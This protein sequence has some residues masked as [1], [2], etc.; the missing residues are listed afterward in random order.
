MGSRTGS[1]LGSSDLACNQ[2][3]FVVLKQPSMNERELT[4]FGNMFGALPTTYVQ[5]QPQRVRVTC[6]APTMQPPMMSMDII[7]IYRL[8]SC[9]LY[10]HM[11]AC[12]CEQCTIQST[13]PEHQLATI[14]RVRQRRTQRNGLNHLN[15]CSSVVGLYSLTKASSN[16]S[17][18][19]VSAWCIRCAWTANQYSR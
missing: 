7:I 13:R 8:V 6:T 16:N 19:P 18:V 17:P 3:A 14:I 2:S 15:K 9:H 11:H 4:A 5:Q 10:M 12:S 1:L